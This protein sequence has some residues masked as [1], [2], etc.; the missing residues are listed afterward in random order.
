ML[1]RFLGIIPKNR[2]ENKGGGLG[3]APGEAASAPSPLCRSPSVIRATR[4]AYLAA[5]S[6]RASI[7]TVLPRLLNWMN[8]S[9][10]SLPVR[11]SSLQAK[12]S[13]TG[14]PRERQAVTAG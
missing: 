2:R 3:D 4:R 10:I 14:I 11:V 8:N 5:F 9:G 12:T 13:C 7:T 1:N 6:S